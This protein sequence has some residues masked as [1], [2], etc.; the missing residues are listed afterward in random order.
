MLTILREDVPWVWSFHPV[1]Y[2]LHHAWL[3]NR[4]PNP[5][6]NNGLKYQR[7]DAEARGAMR[8]KWNEPIVWPVLLVVFVIIASVLPAVAVY[9]RRERRTAGVAAETA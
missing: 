9:R 8:R 2:T 3:S 4:K 1:Q 5:M 7:L 6:A